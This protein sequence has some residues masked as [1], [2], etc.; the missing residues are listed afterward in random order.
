MTC[1]LSA[2]LPAS[3]EEKST[4][5]D[6]GWDDG[7]T[8]QFSQ[9]MG[10]ISE[11]D[12]TGRIIHDVL[13]RGRIGGSLYL[14]GGRLYGFARQSDETRV[15]IRRARFNTRG[16]FTY[17]RHTDYKVE[18][19]Y[20]DGSVFFNDFYLRWKFSRW[21]DSLKVGYF[22]PPVSLDALAG[23]TDRP[24]MELPPPVAAFAPGFRLGAQIS[25]SLAAP[26]LAWALSLSSVGQRPNEG[27]ASSSSP[28]RIT[29]RLVWRPWLD[30]S[31]D[32]PSVLHLGASLRYQISGSGSV[33]FRSRPESYLSDYAV[34]TGDLEGGFGTGGLELAWRR[35]PLLLQAELLGTEIDADGIGGLTFWGAYGQ[36]SFSLTGESHPYDAAEGVFRR[37]VPA[38]PYLPFRGQ[39]G[40]LELA[41]R[42]SWLDLSDGSVNGGRMLSLQLG[43]SWV[44]NSHLRVLAGYLYAHTQDRPEEGSAHVAQLRLEF[45]L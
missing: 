35:G 1:L 15:E 16:E 41:M 40:A 7:P 37:I 17:A 25:G 43:P 44:W 3:A 39:W 19:A 33:R 10:G 14:D 20:D 27:E 31:G 34:D 32:T 22:D 11:Y 21:I 28:I 36:A 29:G 18:F 6:F 26:S 45:A 12:P 24:L 30:E 38:Q 2:A 8:Y 13:L 4:H 9:S 23:T 5:F 42:L